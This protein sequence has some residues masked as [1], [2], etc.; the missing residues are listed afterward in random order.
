MDGI[1]V[2][3]MDGTLKAG[4]QP[5]GLKENMFG[6]NYVT[7]DEYSYINEEIMTDEVIAAGREAADQIISGEIKI[8][9]P[10]EAAQ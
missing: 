9:V 5:G 7:A 1:I 6:V 4:E 10:E 8:E 3:F 2:Q